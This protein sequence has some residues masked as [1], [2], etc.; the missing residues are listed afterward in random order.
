MRA[1]VHALIS[2]TLSEWRRRHGRSRVMELKEEDL[3]VDVSDSGTLNQQSQIMVK[4]ANIVPLAAC[5]VPLLRV[6]A[7]SSCVMSASA[8]DKWSATATIAILRQCQESF[9]IPINAVKLLY[10]LKGMNEHSVLVSN[11][12]SHITVSTLGC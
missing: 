2:M 1:C 8:V 10:I 9:F 3:R 6:L 11:G 4:V 7:Q 12:M 5:N